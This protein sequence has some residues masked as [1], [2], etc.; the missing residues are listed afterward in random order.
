MRVLGIKFIPGS[1]IND[2]DDNG[3]W[4]LTWRES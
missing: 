2:M 4:F 3:D 1:V